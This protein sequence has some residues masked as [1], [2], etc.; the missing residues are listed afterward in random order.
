M[1]V[2]RLQMAQMESVEKRNAERQLEAIH[3]AKCKYFQL[4]PRMT[5]YRD[6]PFCV[7]PL[8]GQWYSQDRQMIPTPPSHVSLQ[9]L[10]FL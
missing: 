7:S 10:L 8:T 4:D 2:F 9:I 1:T 3:V 5:S 6:V